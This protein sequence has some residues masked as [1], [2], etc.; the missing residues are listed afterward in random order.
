MH[1]GWG[2]LLSCTFVPSLKTMRWPSRRKVARCADRHESGAPNH[3]G[4][5]CRHRPPLVPALT[6]VAGWRGHLSLGGFGSR[7]G[8]SAR[9]ALLGFR[10]EAAKPRS[11]PGGFRE[12]PESPRRSPSGRLVRICILA[13]ASLADRARPEP[14]PHQ[15]SH[16]GRNLSGRPFRK[17]LGRSLHAFRGICRGRSLSKSLFGSR[18]R[19][20]ALPLS[21]TPPRRPKP[22][23]R[24]PFR[25]A[26]GA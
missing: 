15:G 2:G 16:R 24:N 8:R 5:R 11:A 6:A 7:G 12:R 26:A 3:N 18:R 9:F 22:S 1:A 4:G 25:V 10:S 13:V 21:R 17:T 23:R 20:K 19:P 14:R